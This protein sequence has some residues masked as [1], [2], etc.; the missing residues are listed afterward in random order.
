M[1]V[2]ACLLISLIPLL[3]TGCNVFS[4][5]DT[6]PRCPAGYVAP[7]PA[8]TPAALPGTVRFGTS[9]NTNLTVH[10]PQVAFGVHQ[11]VA[12]IAHFSHPITSG[13]LRFE[14]FRS[15][16]GRWARVYTGPA[17]PYGPGQRLHTRGILPALRLEFQIIHLGTYQVRYVNSGSTVARG[18]F[19]L[20]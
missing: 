14:I 18:V 20:H 3:L 19:V 7:T 13:T 1:R 11:M 4:I 15:E 2:F 6:A 17:I 12:W 16:C 5:P 9:I 8:P 10:D